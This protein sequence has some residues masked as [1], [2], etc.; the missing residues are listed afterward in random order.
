MLS[1]TIMEATEH[2]QI[3]PSLPDPR[4]KRAHSRVFRVVSW[5][6][7]AAMLCLIF[8][9]SSKSGEA[10]DTGSGIISIVRNALI[11]ATT[12]F[13]GHAIDVSPIG[14]FAEFFLLGLALANAL[15][16]TLPL[17]RAS[18][19]ALICASVYGVTDELHQILVPGRTCDP[20]DWLVDI[21]AAALAVALFA[22]V[23]RL[24]RK[25]RNSNA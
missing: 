18:L 3:T 4:E 23:I 7:V 10:I 2:S 16:L 19:Y 20:M 24:K 9:M 21:I 14:H 6:F 5:F 1:Y 12:S 8:Y 13:F 22:L 17:G 25:R 15:R 11:A